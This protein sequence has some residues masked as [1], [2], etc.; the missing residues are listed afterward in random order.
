MLKS[1]SLKVLEAILIK[2]DVVSV[3][4]S[5]DFVQKEVIS[6]EYTH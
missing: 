6:G 1:Y 4:L 2:T 3:S 5:K